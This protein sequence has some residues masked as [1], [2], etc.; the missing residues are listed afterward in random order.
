[1]YRFSRRNRRRMARF[2]EA[3]QQS[4]HALC[5]TLDITQLTVTPESNY[6]EDMTQMFLASQRR[7]HR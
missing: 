6:G 1:M 3:Q 4:L 5:Q 2:A 7:N